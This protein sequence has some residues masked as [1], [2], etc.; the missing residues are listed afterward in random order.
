MDL[1]LGRRGGTAPKAL[2]ERSPRNIQ[3][4]CKI[5][6]AAPIRMAANSAR[7]VPE[8]V[9]ISTTVDGARFA[10]HASPF[11]SGFKPRLSSSGRFTLADDDR[12]IG[13]NIGRSA[14]GVTPSRQK[15]EPPKR[16]S[17]SGR[18][19]AQRGEEADKRTGKQNPT[20]AAG[21]SGTSHFALPRTLS[22]IEYLRS[23]THPWRCRS[24]PSALSIDYP[25][26]RYIQ[27]GRWSRGA[28]LA[29]RGLSRGEVGILRG[30]S[31]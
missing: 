6:K 5:A 4:S 3:R 19:K 14:V 31:C 22:R 18:R 13:R 25:R 29:K 28:E 27:T 12:A 17:R 26:V 8:A 9:G 16:S 21:V 23:Q 11:P 15:T 30:P 1:L 20:S 7:P 24:G 10:I 2:R